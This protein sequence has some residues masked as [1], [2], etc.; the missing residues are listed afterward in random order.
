[1]SS[2]NRM[3][4]WGQIAST[5]V[6]PSLVETKEGDTT[7]I[8][9]NPEELEHRKRA[10]AV[11]SDLR[12]AELYL[13][14]SRNSKSANQSFALT[15][16]EFYR[17]MATPVCAYSGKTFSMDPQ[18]QYSMSMERVNPQIGYTPENTIA[19]TKA[20]NSEKARLDAFIKGEEIPLEMKIKLMYKAI[21]QMQKQL[22]IKKG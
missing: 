18:S 4:R 7:V 2:N 15:Y 14:K 16:I 17:L 22:K 6:K 11:Q 9:L 1:M 19:V 8:K 12:I 21:Y 3:E 20:A 13:Q 10:N 5:S